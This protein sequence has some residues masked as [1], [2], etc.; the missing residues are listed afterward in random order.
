MKSWRRANTVALAGALVAFVTV[1][2]LLKFRSFMP[3][4]VGFLAYLSLLVL[5]RPRKAASPVPLPDDV[6]REDFDLAM[7]RMVIGARRLRR[8]TPRAPVG[9]RRVIGQMAD[10]IDRIREHHEDNPGHVTQTRRFIR[11]TLGRMVQAVIDYVSL[12]ERAGPEQ[13][14]RLREISAEIAAFVPAL[15]GIDRAC[16]QNDLD[17][18]QVSVEVLNHQ[19]DRHRR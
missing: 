15:E 16:L 11:Q 14:D 12:A 6:S 1:L 5:F 10:L 19:M 9:D 3:L 7:E 2:I 18:L 4:A 13:H 8:E 17:A